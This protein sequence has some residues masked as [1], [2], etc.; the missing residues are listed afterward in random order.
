[1]YFCLWIT[2]EVSKRLEKE[3]IVIISIV[4]YILKKNGYRNYK[5][6]IKLGLTQTM[7]DARLV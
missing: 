3:D 1:M 5:P 4:Y 2:E 6:T 7:K